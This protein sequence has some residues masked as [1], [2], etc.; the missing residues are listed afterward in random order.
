MEPSTAAHILIAALVTY[1][2]I[3]FFVARDMRRRERERDELI[4]RRDEERAEWN[5]RPQSRDPREAPLNTR[6]T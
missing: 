6:I 3:A 5:S 1:L 2:F 4:R